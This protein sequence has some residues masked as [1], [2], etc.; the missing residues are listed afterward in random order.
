MPRS[1]PAHRDVGLVDP[2]QPYGNRGRVRGEDTRNEFYALR[3]NAQ[4]LPEHR[5]LALV[6]TC[7]SVPET[8]FTAT[9][10][11]APSARA[12]QIRRYDA[13]CLTVI[14]YHAG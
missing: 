4:D 8:G 1:G 2:K 7:Q 12:D 6:A 13:R 3:G 11:D 5:Q 9:E 10:F 14:E